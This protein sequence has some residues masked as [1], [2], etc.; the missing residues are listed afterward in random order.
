MVGVNP[1][2]PQGLAG[3]APGS[4]SRAD[5]PAF[6]APAP[7][8]NVTRMSPA[9][10]P[11]LCDNILSA[12]VRH[13]TDAATMSLYSCRTNVNYGLRDPLAPGPAVRHLLLQLYR[14]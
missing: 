7:S 2:P 14:R 6:F 3:G 5:P 4:F 8:D 1:R 13:H 10:Y 12:S 11:R 9:F